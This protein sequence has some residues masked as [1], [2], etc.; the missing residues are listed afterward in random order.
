VLLVA[1]GGV[2]GTGAA[3]WPED[4]AVGGLG[5]HRGTEESTE[6]GFEARGLLDRGRDGGV[7]LGCV[8]ELFL[9]ALILDGIFDRFPDLRGAS[10]EQGAGWVVSWMHHLDHAQRAFRRTEEPLRRLQ[11]RPSEYVHRHL[12]FTPFNGEP[13]GWMIEQAGSDLFMFST[14]YPHPEGG[15]DPLAKFEQSLS[16]ITE[17]DKDRFYARNMAELLGMA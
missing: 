6:L 16:G 4:R 5:D 15:R 11:L 13:V 7:E 2:G 12:K 9:G 17:T 14:D 3:Q 10:I 1:E 8:P